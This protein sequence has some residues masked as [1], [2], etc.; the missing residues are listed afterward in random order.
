M[1]NTKNLSSEI[2]KSEIDNKGAKC[3]GIYDDGKIIGT[4]SVFKDNKK[5]WYTDSKNCL[6]IKYV[7]VAPESQGRHVGSA[8]MDFVKAKEEYEILNV[9]TGEKNINAIRYYE[10][11]GFV[12]VDVSRGP[13]H[14]AYKLA[15][16]RDGCPIK[17]RTIK[18]HVLVSKIK[19]YV[20]RLFIR[21]KVSKEMY[22]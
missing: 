14:N 13:I 22:Q 1:F 21:T 5:H 3:I 18:K 11:N 10:R 12:L 2:L 6:E 4:L 19:C 15:Y 17:Q 8:L 9:S 20:K 7:A 16:W